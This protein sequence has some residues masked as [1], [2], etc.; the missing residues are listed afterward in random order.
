MKLR[1][2]EDLGLVHRGV[3]DDRPPRALYSF[4]QT[5]LMIVRLGEPVFPYL[6]LH[7][8][9]AAPATQSPPVNP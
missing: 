4:T 7:G 1:Q 8:P 2:M 5:G 3:L 6:R 9:A